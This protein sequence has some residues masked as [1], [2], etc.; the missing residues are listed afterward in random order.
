MG[1]E[2]QVKANEFIQQQRRNAIA[3][4][5]ITTQNSNQKIFVI[6]LSKHAVQQ[7]SANH[8]KLTNFSTFALIQYL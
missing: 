2:V 7:L 4:K 5:P 8:Y 3:T 6:I 1:L